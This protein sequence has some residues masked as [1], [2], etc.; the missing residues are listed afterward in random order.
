MIP[1]ENITQALEPGEIT[2]QTFLNSDVA[3]LI[4]YNGNIRQIPLDN[5]FVRKLYGAGGSSLFC[6]DGFNS[7][8]GNFP[9][10]RVFLQGDSSSPFVLSLFTGLDV[11]PSSSAPEV[12]AGGFVVWSE[13]K[14]KENIKALEN[15]SASKLTPKKFAIA[16]REVAGLVVEDVEVFIPEAISTS[17]DSESGETV[18]GWRMEGVLAHLLQ[19]FKDF[20]AEMEERVLFLEEKLR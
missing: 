14:N 4:V 18:K 5:A 11:G 10:R 7:L 3:L 9:T 20:K 1:I 17:K 15:P 8:R 13:E 12:R 6:E 16:G 2:L 19:E